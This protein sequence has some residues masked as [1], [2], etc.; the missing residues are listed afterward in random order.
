[1]TD[2]IKEA[3]FMRIAMAVAAA[4]LIIAFAAHA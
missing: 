4:T 3:Y 2:E 1:M